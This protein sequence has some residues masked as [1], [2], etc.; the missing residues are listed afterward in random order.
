M[1]IFISVA[2]WFGKLPTMSDPV[3]LGGGLFFKSVGLA[4]LADKGVVE[5]TVAVEKD[6]SSYQYLYENRL[7]Y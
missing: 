4:V 5:F 7:F 6:S 2:T 1:K 3:V